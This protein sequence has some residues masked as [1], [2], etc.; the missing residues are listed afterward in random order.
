[1]KAITRFLPGHVLPWLF[2]IALLGGCHGQIQL[3]PQGSQAVPTHLPVPSTNHASAFVKH[4]GEDTYCMFYGLGPG[5]DWRAIRNRH[6]CWSRGQ[7]REI[8]PHPRMQPVLA[9]TAA[10][11][12]QT[13]YVIGGYT[14]NAAGEEKS[15]PEIYALEAGS[16]KFRLET[17]MPVAVDDTVALVYQNRYLYLISGW[18]DTDN[19]NRVQVYDTQG[20]RWFEATPYPAPA[21]FGHAGGLWENR[22]VVCDGVK[23]IKKT[24][25]NRVIKDFVMSPVC[26]LGTIAADNPANIDWQTI[27]HP[28]NPGRYRMAATAAAGVFVFAAGSETAYNYDGIGYNGQPAQPVAEVLRYSPA[29]KQWQRETGKITPVMD[30]RGLPW[31]GQVFVLLGGMDEK[32]RVTDNVI[33]FE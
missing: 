16:D 30:F 5:K 15:T 6:W 12:G 25:G 18:H 33:T 29:N 21:V 13:I 32:Q 14:V 2:L 11:V 31:N 4:Q 27:P 7:W 10:T 22:L 1:M 26:L 17:H 19:V 3:E 8:P 9:A 24:V 23:V 28:P 20:K